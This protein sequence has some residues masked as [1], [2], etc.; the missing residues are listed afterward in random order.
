MVEFEEKFHRELQ[1]LKDNIPPDEIYEFALKAF[2]AGEYFLYRWSKW[3]D[4]HEEYQKNQMA[5]L[6]M[7]N[8]M[9]VRMLIQGEPSDHRNSG[10][11]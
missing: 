4:L 6:L 11:P 7:Y 5:A 9:A 1:W 8:I 10:D 3:D 2:M